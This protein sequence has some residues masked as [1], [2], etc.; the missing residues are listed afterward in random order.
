MHDFEELRQKLYDSFCGARL[1][2]SNVERLRIAIVYHALEKELKGIDS[3]ISAV[4]S[5][6][7]ELQSLFEKGLSQSLADLSDNHKTELN[8]L[9]SELKGFVAD[10]LLLRKWVSLGI[11]FSEYKLEWERIE[12]IKDSLYKK[13]RPIPF[14]RYRS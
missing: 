3:G 1:I 4:C 12:K 13:L 8:T 11:S 7:D 5:S 6:Y 9:S 2:Q 10:I 14:G